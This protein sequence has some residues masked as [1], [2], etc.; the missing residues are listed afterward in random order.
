MLSVIEPV[1][2]AISAM[3]FLE[4]FTILATIFICAF[5][6]WQCLKVIAKGFGQLKRLTQEAQKTTPVGAR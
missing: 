5:V 3:P 4:V 1:I 2:I 6:A